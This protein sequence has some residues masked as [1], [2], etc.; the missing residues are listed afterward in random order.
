MSVFILS[1]N[2]SCVKKYIKNHIPLKKCLKI[3]IYKKK[4]V[5]LQANLDEC[6]LK[7]TSY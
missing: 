4:A 5:P 7:A 2:Y 6:A 3:C 1:N